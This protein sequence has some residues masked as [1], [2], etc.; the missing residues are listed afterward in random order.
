VQ[1]AKVAGAEVTGVDSAAKLDLMRTVGADHVMDH[2]MEDFAATGER[3]DRIIDMV[4]RRSVAAYGRALEPGGLCVIVGGSMRVILAAITVGR[5][6]EARDGTHVGLLMHRPNLD[7]LARLNEKVE[8]GA[9][10]PVIDRVYSLEQVPEALRR[11]GAGD[12]LGKV[13]IRI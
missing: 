11:M 1:L 7:D 6:L 10:K 4:A 12:V 9:L 13:V 8:T 3:Y 5:M 2:A